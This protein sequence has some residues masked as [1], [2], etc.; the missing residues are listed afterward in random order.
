VR[1]IVFSIESSIIN[2]FM[3]NLA[4]TTPRPAVRAAAPS[5]KTKVLLVRQ[6]VKSV[7]KSDEPDRTM[8]RLVIGVIVA[9][10][11]ISAVWLIGYLG[12]RLGFADLVRVRELQLDAGGGL[13]T[14]T[15]MLIS[16]PQIILQ[17]GIDQPI[18][19]MVGFWLIAIPAAV[20][21][22]IRPSAPGGPRPKAALVAMSYFGA[23]AAVINSVA[24]I[25]WT[26]SPYRNDLLRE[27]PFD[28]AD[29]ASWLADLQTA[30]GLDVL[31]T[32]AASLWVVVAMRLHIPIWLRGLSASACYFALV[33][34]AVAMS[35]SNAAASMISADRSVFFLDDGS[36]ETRL[37][38]GHTPR[39]LAT[40][41][42]RDGRTFVELRDRSE[43]LEVVGK[44]SILEFL[45]D[46]A[47]SE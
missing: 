36:I 47:P 31:G 11:T 13:A 5:S 7:R 30:G 6:P 44:Q 39:A 4:R 35:M 42:V 25:A 14:G 17:A 10:G 28:P 45:G 3:P 37:V 27:L 46:R 29:A 22:G 19:L 34:T 24:L 12:F 23:I 16:M 43:V 26:V 32:I 20:L 1:A 33:V 21:G 41:N 40:L 38:L 2:P 9:L 18:W 8:L 15:L